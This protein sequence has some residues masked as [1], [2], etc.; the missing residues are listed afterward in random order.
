MILSLSHT[1]AGVP[2][3]GACGGVGTGGR[4]RRRGP[5]SHQDVDAPGSRG[6]G[7]ECRSNLTFKSLLSYITL[8][9]VCVI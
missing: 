6:G 5:A 3:E 4:L 8:E 1:P 7:A 9:S 2:E